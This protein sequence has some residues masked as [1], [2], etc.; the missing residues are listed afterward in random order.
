MVKGKN[1]STPTVKVESSLKKKTGTA[2]SPKAART[3]APSSGP[4]NQ[5]IRHLLYKTGG[6]YKK[7]E[8]LRK[9]RLTAAAVETIKRKYYQLIDQDVSA[10]L[11]VLTAQGVRV[12]TLDHV[13]K[14][15]HLHDK[16]HRCGRVDVLI[17][18]KVRS[19]GPQASSSA[20]EETATVQVKKES[21]PKKIKVEKEEK[22]EVVESED[23]SEPEDGADNEGVEDDSEEDEDEVGG[24]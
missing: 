15:L 6:D 22:K 19:K 20:T 8:D 9:I 5:N 1:L 24:F 12:L 14:A 21:A 7:G 2:P 17:V 3:R 18:K 13:G 4:S 11:Q 23:D 16:M 10:A